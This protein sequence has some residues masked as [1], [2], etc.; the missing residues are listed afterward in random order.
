MKRNRAAVA[1]VSVALATVF[2]SLASATAVAAEDCAPST[3]AGAVDGEVTLCQNLDAEEQQTFWFLG[4]GSQIIPYD[5]FLALRQAGGGERF[6]APAHMDGF[7]YLPQRPTPDNP[8]GLPVGFTAG[9]AKANPAYQAISDRWLGLTCAACHTGQVEY[10]NNGTLHKILVDGAPTMAD[11][12]SFML[13]L[14][15][16][17]QATLDD[18]N[19]FASFAEEVFAL[20]HAEADDA[21]EL[22]GQLAFMT[23]RRRAWNDRNSGYADPGDTSGPNKRY[24]F[25]RLDAIGAIFNQI[26]AVGIG[27]PGN[28]KPADAP[29]SYPFVWDTPQHDFVQWNGSVANKGAGALGR[30]V[31]EVL[32]VFGSLDLNDSRFFRTGHRTSVEV[33]HLGRLEKL[34]WKLWSPQWPERLLPPIDRSLAAQG[35][36]VFEKRC[37]ACHEDIDRTD[38]NRRLTANL[39]EVSKLRTDPAMATN[40]A[41]RRSA[42]RGGNANL[43][44][45]PARYLKLL[46]DGQRLANPDANARFLAFAVTGTITNLLLT[47][48]LGTVQALKA[49]QP[50]KFATLVEQAK[51]ERRRGAKSAIESAAELITRIEAAAA[52][53]PP[54]ACALPKLCYK[55]RNLN[56]IWATAP[57][58]HNG[59]VRTMRQL[60][61]PVRMRQETFRVGTRR[62]DPL[63]MGFEDAGGYLFD[64]SV[65]GN[66]NAGHIYSAEALAADQHALDAL[67]E[68]LKTL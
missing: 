64:T 40:F 39:L 28:R 12:E 25:G 5:W 36:V 2:G 54:P 15:E 53:E 27:K 60:L 31:G 63:G 55:G 23:E 52:K 16:A 21:A 38:P 19:R 68:Y 18:A 14:V 45:R 1:L 20:G 24:G 9:G 44:G 33:G 35:R 59:S 62:F 10:E 42:A 13:A 67:L 51:R 7:R 65:D 11:F 17:M 6:A 58:L 29:V 4:Q 37:L 34:I 47:D 46:S 56:G 41:S 50:P 22:R 57:Y 26:T 32:G 8:D 30:N 61:L 49:G 3:F 66:S 43:R 48:P